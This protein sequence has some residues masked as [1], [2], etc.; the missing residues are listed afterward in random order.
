MNR[1]NSW[2][3]IRKTFGLR[4]PVKLIKN[5]KSSNKLG[6][7]SDTE[8]KIDDSDEE[9]C[10]SPK[11]NATSVKKQLN[12]T[13]ASKSRPS[14]SKSKPKPKQN[15][16]KI[17]SLNTT[18]NSSVLDDSSVWSSGSDDYI[19]AEPELHD[20][21]ESKITSVNRSKRNRYRSLSF[22]SI[23]KSIQSTPKPDEATSNA[24]SSSNVIQNRKRGW[25]NLRNVFDGKHSSRSS[26]N[27]DETII[28]SDSTGDEGDVGI[29]SPLSKKIRPPNTTT[30]T[31]TT[32]TSLIRGTNN[33]L[34]LIINTPSTSSSI[35]QSIKNSSPKNFTPKDK[36]LAKLKSVKGGSLER[37]EKVISRTKSD[38]SFWMNERMV[39]LVEPGE[40]LCI[41]KVQQSYGRVLLYCE[42]LDNATDNDNDNDNG[43]NR[44]GDG[45]GNGNTHRVKVLCVD[46]AY[47]KMSTLQVGKAIEVVLESTGYGIES[48]LHFYPH[49]SKILS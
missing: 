8:I 2:K 42:S 4:S 39:D 3:N 1:S 24:E 16:R 40:K 13:S 43:G 35:Q 46:P 20:V 38:Y 31:V 29:K 14:S 44:N 17:L 12:S 47:K 37:L 11:K 49:I 48:D 34:N 33:G 28:E 32:N 6:P 25:P 15:S 18:I 45:S 36:R 22:I 7:N 5:K 26:T 23:T 10:S 30:S 9:N 41:K 27:L 19:D 21:S